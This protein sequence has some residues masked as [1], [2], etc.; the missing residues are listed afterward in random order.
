MNYVPNSQAVESEQAVWDFKENYGISSIGQTFANLTNS[1][2]GSGRCSN[3][4]RSTR[5]QL[6][7]HLPPQSFGR[8]SRCCRAPPPTGS[9]TGSD[10]SL[11]RDFPRCT[12]DG[13]RHRCRTRFRRC[14]TTKC[15][16]LDHAIG[17]HLRILSIAWREC[18]RIL[19][20]HIIV[21]LF[22]IESRVDDVAAIRTITQPDIAARRVPGFSFGR[23]ETI[24]QRRNA[25][26]TNQWF[27]GCSPADEATITAFPRHAGSVSRSR[28][29]NTRGSQR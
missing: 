24:A 29:V 28:I 7:G 21:D 13:G 6:R 19:E 12:G 11:R 25:G 9:S 3:T 20:A 27:E 22:L 23:T 2:M 18:Q 4:W 26:N 17:R 8:L 1:F 5:S 15:V 16:S 10:H 14:V